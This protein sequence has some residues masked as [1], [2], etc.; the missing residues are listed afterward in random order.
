MS[1]LKEVRVKI[2]EV[3]KQMAK[4]FEQRMNLA[5]QVAENKI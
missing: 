2:N 5:K 1:D 3:D 4:L